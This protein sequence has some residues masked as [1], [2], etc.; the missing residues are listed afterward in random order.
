MTER[1]LFL[2]VDFT[3]AGDGWYE[4][5][6]GE[7]ARLVQGLPMWSEWRVVKP[8]GGLPGELDAAS[9]AA[10]VRR[11]DSRGFELVAAA[12]G[13]E[14]ALEC[15]HLDDTLRIRIEVYDQ[16]W[17]RYAG[18]LESIAWTLIEGLRPGVVVPISGISP[19][20]SPDLPWDEVPNRPIANFLRFENVVSFVDSRL[21]ALWGALDSGRAIARILAAP[22]PAGARR[23]E[24]DGVALVSFTDALTDEHALAAARMQHERWLV[25]CVRPT[26]DRRLTVS[27]QVEAPPLSFVDP[28]ALLGF[29]TVVVFPD[30]SRQDD[31]WQAA[32]ATAR[33]G[34]LAP[35]GRLAGVYVIVPLREHALTLSR[36]ATAEGLAGV[37]YPDDH[38]GLWVVTSAPAR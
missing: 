15:R 3:F 25:E 36:Q 22:V 6:A 17:A 2:N 37:C 12:S 21:V 26:G 14:V 1:G 24:R 34:Q 23:V 30:G 13:G 38:G 18:Q 28:S 11:P 9:L 32:V 20:F 16:A 10:A 5:I 33:A 19:Q 35:F 4:S 27:E 8:R 31:A 7:L 29:K